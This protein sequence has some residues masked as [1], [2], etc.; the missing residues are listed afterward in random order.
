MNVHPLAEQHLEFLSLNGGCTG[1]P[2]STL[3][4][5][6][7]CWKSYVAAQLYS[8]TIIQKARQPALV[9]SARRIITRKDTRNY[10][11]Y[12][13]V[14]PQNLFPID[15]NLLCRMYFPTL[16]NWTCPFPIFGLLG[17]I[18]N[19]YS[20]FKRNF[21]KQTVDNL[22]RRRVLRRLIWFCTDWQCPTKRTL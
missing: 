13:K 19:F 10:S 21:C 4:K 12:P 11:Q 22:I 17:V 3:V 15:F 6:Q 18:F 5:M 16:I 20:T 2:E 8:Q 1:K 7:H 9:S 14:I